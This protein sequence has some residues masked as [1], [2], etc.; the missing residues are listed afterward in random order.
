MAKRKVKQ[1]KEL[2]E[3][4][5][6]ARVTDKSSKLLGFLVKSN[7][8]SEYYQITCVKIGNERF[9]TCTREAGQR[10]FTTCKDGKCCHVQAV[11]EVSEAR[12]EL[13]QE[14]A[15][16]VAEAERIVQQITIAPLYAEAYNA[17]KIAGQAF[18]QS[19]PNM[20]GPEMLHAGA[21]VHNN[22]RELNYKGWIAGFQ[23]GYHG[24]FSRCWTQLRDL[25]PL[26]GR[27]FRVES[28]PELNGAHIPLK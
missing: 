10:G 16:A 27:G 4:A 24:E 18:R 2:I 21:I 6:I 9:F 5:T 28:I 8:S 13:A 1:E 11:I 14:Q 22:Q 17:G 20:N 12:K 7:S 15:A 19:H 3:A 26:N 25:A 23:D